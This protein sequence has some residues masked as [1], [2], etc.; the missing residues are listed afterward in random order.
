[1]VIQE[2]VEAA[3][4]ELQRYLQD[5]IP[6]NSA[7]DAIAALMA[8]PP[9]VVMQRVAAW[10]VEQSRGKSVPVS[11]LLLH[12][13]RKIHVTGELRLLDREAVANYLDRVTTI[14][15]RLCPAENRDRLRNDIHVMRMSDE[16][17]IHAA[18]PTMRMPT[19][20]GQTPVPEDEGQVAKRFSLVFD[21]LKREMESSTSETAQPEPQALAQLLTMAATRSQTGQQ[22]ND[23]MN[24]IRP[25]TGGKEGNVFVILAGGVPSWDMASL[26]PGSYK[27]PAQV[28]AMEKIIDLAEDPLVAMKRFREIV[29]A[30]IEKFN[31]GSLGAAVWMLDVAEDTI[32]ERKLEIT[33]VDQIRAEVAENVS[34]VQ[35]RKYTEKKARH[36]ALKLVLEFFPTLHLEYVLGHLRGEA[37]A[38]RRR[39]LL[40]IIEAYGISG[41]DAALANL[42]RELQ[43]S[44][45][46][47]YYLRNLIFLLHRISRQSDDGIEREMAAVAQASA[48]G[49]NIYVI[50]E[51][52]TALGQI[53]T[54]ASVKALTT[55]LAEFEATLLRNDTSS[56]PAAE[57]QK[58]LDRIIAAL[59][60]IGTPGALLTIARHGMK[61]NPALGDT[62]ARLAA[63]AQH[64]LSFDEQTVNVLLKAL[65]DDVPGK[66]LGRLLPKSQDSTVRL[67]EALSG[68]RADAVEEMFS[69]IAQRFA[70]QDIGRAAAQVLEKWSPAEAPGREP[71]ATLTGELEF[72][73]LPSVMQSLGE[74]RATGMLTL[75]TKQGQAAAKLAV[76]DGKFL[77]AQ[78]GIVRGA[79]ALYDVLERPIS[80]TFAFVPYPTEKMKSDL[81]P[82]EIMGVLLEGVRRHDELQRILALV[83]DGMALAKTNVKPTPH[84]EEDDP[85]FIRDVWLKASGGAA[86]AEWEREMPTDSYRVRRLVAHWVEQGAL[87]QK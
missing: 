17:T 64:D 45:V 38:E 5:E 11:D 62:R 67:I 47:T 43:R 65:R 83:P 55:R 40:G 20:S 37:R 33:A 59:A 86:V 84:E 21:R 79:E 60:R 8:Q 3:L 48:P 78:R 15:L 18:I 73:G 10:S 85:A 42:D 24:M 68:T 1:M 81:A 75:R 76:V 14:A 32:T 72:F 61:A 46:D 52:A 39:T 36:A 71:A 31:D 19:L 12:A 26:A 22:L 51:A 74:M 66:L 2:R 16:T 44:D 41:R 7:A 57:M 23:Y 69:D 13:L 80:G 58:L 56:Y 77:N 29:A 9:E 25:L 54:D 70:D 63:L 30:A 34:S 82:R 28:A 35:L 53:K 27:P 4:W 87:V 50:K 6:P 49:Q